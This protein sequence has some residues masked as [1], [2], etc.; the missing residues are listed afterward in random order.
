M[1]N[2]GLADLKTKRNA[3][4]GIWAWNRR[5]K[6]DE[7]CPYCGVFKSVILAVVFQQGFGARVKVIGNSKFIR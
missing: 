5:G 1:L 4:V 2:I 3:L 6:S 7:L